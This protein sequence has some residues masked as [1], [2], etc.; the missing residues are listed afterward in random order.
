VVLG[1]AGGP[2]DPSK[3]APLGAVATRLADTAVFTEEDHRDTPLADILAEMERGATEAGRD[4]FVSIG[5]RVQAIRY[6]VDGAAPEDTVVLAGKG[7]EHTLERDTETIPWDE[8][9]QAREAVR[10]RRV[11]AADGR[12]DD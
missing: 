11:Q 8:M 2:R 1:S 7:P 6:A 12:S 9:A 4:N 3:R 5:D 10:S